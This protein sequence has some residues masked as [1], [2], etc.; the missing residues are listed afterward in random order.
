MK[1]VLIG[2]SG[3]IGHRILREAI[4][5]GHEVTAISRNPEKQD[6]KHDRVKWVSLNI[7]NTSL[8]KEVIMRHD[9]VISAYGPGQG[10]DPHNVITTTNSIIEAMRQSGTKRL[11][12]VGGAGS[13]EVSPGVQLVD[14]PEFPEAW[15]GG[16]LAHRDALRIYQKIDDIDWTYMSPAAMIVPGERTGKFRLGKGQLLT[17]EKGNST[18]S[19]E[20]FAVALMNEIENPEHIHKRFTL[21]Y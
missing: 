7:L 8:L 21:A 4:N 5:R 2:G 20:D 1:L 16:A 15:K 6:V 14:T 12:V 17:D 13:L 9:A 3:N 18:I 11:L 10:E 19:M